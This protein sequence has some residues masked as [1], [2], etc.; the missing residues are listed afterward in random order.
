MSNSETPSVFATYII[1]FNNDLTK[2][3]NIYDP[4]R[5]FGTYFP[6][7]CCFREH[8]PENYSSVPKFIGHVRQELKS[9][10][11]FFGDAV[12][13]IHTRY[14]GSKDVLIFTKFSDINDE[15]LVRNFEWVNISIIISA[16]ERNGDELFGG[17]FSV[18]A[19]KSILHTLQ[20]IHN[21]HL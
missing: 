15:S 3:L 7:T 8:W 12:F 17:G 18:S 21:T 2:I 20:A 10:S 19:R 13:E 5:T 1:C 4:N 9:D 11:I 14:N 16:L 6:S